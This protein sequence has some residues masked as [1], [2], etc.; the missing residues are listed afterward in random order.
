MQIP[1][2]IFNTKSNPDFTVASE[3][4]RTLHVSFAVQVSDWECHLSRCAT[5]Q[6]VDAR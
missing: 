1:R 5:T 2:V 4:S 6:R 3:G